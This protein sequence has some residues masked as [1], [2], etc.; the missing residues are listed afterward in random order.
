MHWSLRSSMIQSISFANVFQG[1]VID[2]GNTTT[3][4]VLVKLC[5]EISWPSCDITLFNFHWKHWGWVV[6]CLSMPSTSLGKF[7]QYY[8]T[9][10]IVGI[11]RAMW[12]IQILWNNFCWKQWL[13]M[14][15]G[16]LLLSSTS[17]EKYYPCTYCW[18]RH[19]HFV[20]MFDHS[21]PNVPQET[22]SRTSSELI[23]QIP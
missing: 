5:S 17:L 4:I 6:E 14:T 22:I 16:M 1:C 15:M 7:S 2:D 21:C 23:A 18:H 13:L 9:E 12:Y 3:A 10:T 19:V 20:H 8:T 11:N